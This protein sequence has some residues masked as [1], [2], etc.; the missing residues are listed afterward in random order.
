MS[1]GAVGGEHES[2]AE[3][4]ARIRAGAAMRDLGH[5]F[6]G[7]HMTVDQI[8][9]LSDALESISA[10]LWPGMP[11][12]KAGVMDSP[13]SDGEIPQGRIDQRFSDRPMSGAASPWGL[14][15]D[16]H[17]HGDEIEARLQLGAAHEGAPGRCHGGIVASLFDDVCGHV[18]GIVRQPAFTGELTVRYLAPTPLHREL[19]C[20][21]RLADRH[22]RKLFV[23][24]ELVDVETGEVLATA[25]TLFIA[26]KV[27]HFLGTAERPA[28]PPDE[29]YV[30]PR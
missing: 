21:A 23:T 1:D 25:K 10:E 24:G 9:R 13:A 5:A 3:E 8:D 14:D 20:R 29:H 4:Q 16:V 27:E 17:R 19:A 26:V 18:L 12:R 28:P 22:G 11:R 30:R 2:P 6:V 7:R 15:L